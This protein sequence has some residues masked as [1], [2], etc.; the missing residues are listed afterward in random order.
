MTPTRWSDESTDPM[1][2]DP[3]ERFDL[4][5]LI[6]LIDIRAAVQED[7]PLEDYDDEEPT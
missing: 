1:D 4:V 6:N 2:S 7:F 5:D 3:F